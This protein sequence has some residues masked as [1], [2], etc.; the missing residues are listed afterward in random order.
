MKCWFCA[1]WEGYLSRVPL[2]LLVSL[3]FSSASICYISLLL[4]KPYFD[5][6]RTAVAFKLARG[7]LSRGLWGNFFP[8]ELPD[9]ISAAQIVD[10]R[11][12]TLFF[13]R[14]K[15]ERCTKHHLHCLRMASSLELINV[16]CPFSPS[17]HPVCWVLKMQPVAWVVY[18]SKRWDWEKVGEQTKVKWKCLSSNS[19]S[20]ARSRNL[21]LF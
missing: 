16:H 18:N 4:Y 8:H 12:D 20:E 15:A 17:E 13:V 10:F 5:A 6:C 14:A 2:S 9:G 1:L 7:H 11:A 21:L 19:S 3:H